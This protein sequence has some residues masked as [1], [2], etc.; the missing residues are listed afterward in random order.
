MPAFIDFQLSRKF[1]AEY[2]AV[3]FSV[4]STSVEW[5]RENDL[6]LLNV[7]Y[8]TLL[9]NSAADPNEH[10]WEVFCMQAQ[11]GCEFLKVAFLFL[12]PDVE[13]S[14]APNA[15]QRKKEMVMALCERF[16]AMI[17]DWG[18]AK[19]GKGSVLEAFIARDK[20]VP[21]PTRAEWAKEAKHLVPAKYLNGRDP[22]HYK[23]YMNKKQEAL[24]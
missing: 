11:L 2:D 21:Q 18:C 13:A 15:D 4:C 7:F 1:P 24:D 9:E 17:E 3:Y 8:D 12:T 14:M 5:R 23:R 16:K 20:A 10:T 6:E 19:M 22:S